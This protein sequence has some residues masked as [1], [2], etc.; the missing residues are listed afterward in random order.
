MV[1]APALVTRGL[2]RQVELIVLF[3]KTQSRD[4]HLQVLVRAPSA[5]LAACGLKGLGLNPKRHAGL[6]LVAVG[7]VGK[8]SRATKAFGDQVGVDVLVDQVPWRGHL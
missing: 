5:F 2:V 8:E 7:F 4:A 1:H 3:H 6:T